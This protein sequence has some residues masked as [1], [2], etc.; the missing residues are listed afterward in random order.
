[1][2]NLNFSQPTNSPPKVLCLGAHCDDIEIGCGGTILRW[3]AEHAGLEVYWVVLSSNRQ[4]KKE[5]ARCAG[6]FLKG[7]RQPK[8]SI[9]NFRDGFFPY[10]GAEI[11]EYFEALKKRVSPDIVLTHYRDDRHQDHRLVSDLTWNTFRRELILEYEI[12]KYD[13]DLGQPNLFVPLSGSVCRRKIRHILDVFKTQT[14]KH[15]LTEDTLYA[16]L[17][18]RGVESHAE[19]KY[20]EAFYCR[21]M[22]L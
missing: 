19:E 14:Q 21:K 17:R 12:P 9:E 3:L 2:L 6:L 18:L 5:A 10:Q 8:V 16:L 7:A 11:K 20:A 13:G 1:M 22:I 15:W 4:R